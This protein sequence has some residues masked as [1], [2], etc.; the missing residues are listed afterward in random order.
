MSDARE[1][2]ESAQESS[3]FKRCSLLPIWS[4]FPKPQ[5][6]QRKGQEKLEL[7]QRPGLGKM[8]G[9]ASVADNAQELLR[10]AT[11]AKQNTSFLKLQSLTLQQESVFV[12][13]K[14]AFLHLF[15]KSLQSQTYVANAAP[16]PTGLVQQN[17]RRT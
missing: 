15:D 17:P 9:L 4:R 1:S 10:P 8:R 13:I 3:S 11:L 5:S 2:A 7:P 12:W 16:E 14:R 6:K